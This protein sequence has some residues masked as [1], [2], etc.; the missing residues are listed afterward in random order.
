V[1]GCAALIVEL[2]GA[3]PTMTTAAVGIEAT[4]SKEAFEA[5]NDETSIDEE[6]LDEY[7][8]MVDQ[9]GSF[10]VG[11]VRANFVALRPSP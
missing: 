9:L 3:P 10:P 2:Q 1:N 4:S 7:R 8:E 6:Q 11:G 5:E